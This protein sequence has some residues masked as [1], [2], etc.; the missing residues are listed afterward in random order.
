M[1]IIKVITLVVFLVFN[2]MFNIL[3]EKEVVV[4]KEDKV[5]IGVID[6][7]ENLLYLSDESYV[8]NVIFRKFV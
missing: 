7:P 3:Q 6:L 1:R 4:Y 2:I 5:T 8:N